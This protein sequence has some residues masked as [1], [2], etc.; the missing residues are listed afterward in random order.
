MRGPRI[1]AALFVIALAVPAAA[2]SSLTSV[3]GG[4]PSVA[5][6]TG[7][8]GFQLR[9]DETTKHTFSDQPAFAWAPSP[10]A[11]HYEFQVARSSAFRD[12]AILYE[13]DGLPSPTA[14]IPVTLPWGSGQGTGY[15]FYARVR[16]VTANGT[17]PWSASFGFNMRWPNLPTQL[18]APDGLMRW[19][20]VVGANAY[21]VWEIGLTGTGAKAGTSKIVLTTTNVADERDWYTFHANNAD[22]SWYKAIH[23]RVR[24]LRVSSRG[25]TSNDFAR[26]SYGPWSPLY[27]STNGARPVAPTPLADATTVSDTLGTPASP[28]VHGLMPGF[29]WSGNASLYGTKSELYRVYIFSDSDCLNPVYA[30]AAVGSPAYAPRL[31]GT[32]AL[33]S[34]QAAIDEART[35][36]LS[37]GAE[38]LTVTAD[39]A[40]TIA[41]ESLNPNKA[42]IDP[43]DPTNTGQKADDDPN[44][45]DP[46]ANPTAT[47]GAA[48]TPTASNPTVS[49]AQ[50]SYD[51]KWVDLWDTD[52]PSNGY[53]WTVVPVLPVSAGAFSTTLILSSAATT[54]SITVSTPGLVAGDSISIGSGGATAEQNS[55]ASVQGSVVTLGAPLKFN[56]GAGELVIRS[57]ALNYSEQELW[58]DACA[59]GRVMRFGKVSQ[60]VV[61]G[62]GQPFISGL[63]TNGKVV[64][65]TSTRTFYGVPVI[66]WQPAL[67]AD[68]YQIQWS[69]TGY[70]FTPMMDKI[71]VGTSS[72]MS[73]KAVGFKPGTYY[74]RVRGIDLQ[75]PKKAR[76]MGW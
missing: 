58:Q 38:G 24:A 46:A 37:N 61:T 56:H 25:P 75:L 48:T 42:A 50:I 30:G 15:G 6:P 4:T 32:L 2:S 74:Y 59:S 5:A 9:Y 16:A 21:E 36:V 35:E 7:L 29:G 64:A 8:K 57:S 20:P 34:T 39:G 62:G 54:T 65:G 44:A 49:P 53:Y 73:S 51:S 19:A 67:G 55:V 71:A 28:A 47:A 43:L 10:N 63:G 27:T 41:S 18:T 12:S 60:P 13:S 52:W 33:P 40:P 23:W 14:T 26:T 22:T 1:A 66:T 69:A 72:L 11:Q 3:H 70:P 45:P 76:G 68:E 31:S 17:T